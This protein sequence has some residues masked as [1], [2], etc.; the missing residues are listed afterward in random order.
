MKTKFQDLKLNDVFIYIYN[1]P[2]GSGDNVTIS[3]NTYIA[4]VTKVGEGGILFKDIHKLNGEEDASDKLSIDFKKALND[5]T[6]TDYNYQFV[7]YMFYQVD[8][9]ERVREMRPEYFI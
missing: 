1:M 5:D 2:S 6:S 4:I 8:A 9:I 7:E 3:I